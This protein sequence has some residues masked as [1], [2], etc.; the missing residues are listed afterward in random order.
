MFDVAQ[1]LAKMRNLYAKLG[2][3]IRVVMMDMDLKNIKD[4]DG[5][6]FLDINATTSQK[7]MLE[8]QSEVSN[9]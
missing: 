1:I 3:T 5:T 8:K 6:G 9:C 4:K 7:N 2:F